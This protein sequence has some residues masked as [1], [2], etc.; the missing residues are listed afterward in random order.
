MKPINYSQTSELNKDFK[1]FLKRFRT[2]KEDFEIMKK[3]DNRGHLK[4]IKTNAAVKM[5]NFC[6]QD[7]LSM[8]A[9]KMACKS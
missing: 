8:K 1:E 6:S 9:R 2:L 4:N 7:Y 3:I 5:Q